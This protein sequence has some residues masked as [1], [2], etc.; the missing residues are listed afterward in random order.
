MRG[1]K[2]LF[3]E[4]LSHFTCQNS[5][6]HKGIFEAIVIALNSRVNDHVGQ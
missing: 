3:T 6:K 1:G 5:F 4:K 2:N